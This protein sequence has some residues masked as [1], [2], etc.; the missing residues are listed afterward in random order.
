MKNEEH[1]PPPPPHL[2]DGEMG[3]FWFLQRFI[4]D[5]GG[6]VGRSDFSFY[7]VQDCNLGQFK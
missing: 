4:I 5:S 1:P 7:S 3:A 6:G 2:N